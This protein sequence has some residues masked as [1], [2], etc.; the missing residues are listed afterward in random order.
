M[1]C[2]SVTGNCQSTDIPQDG[3]AHGLQWLVLGRSFGAVLCKGGLSVRTL[4]LSADGVFWGL[5]A[6]M[7]SVL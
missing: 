7:A 2:S 4:V 6:Y 3:C 5:M 1:M